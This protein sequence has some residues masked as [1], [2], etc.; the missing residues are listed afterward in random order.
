MK[1]RIEDRGLRIEGVGLFAIVILGLSLCQQSV[2]GRGA[3]LDQASQ[4]LGRDTPE[5]TDRPL[6]KVSKLSELAPT[7]VDELG[8][9]HYFRLT[10]TPLEALIGTDLAIVSILEGPGRM[11]SGTGTTAADYRAARDERVFCNADVLFLGSV[12]DFRTLLNEGATWLITEYTVAR[13]AAIA[14]TDL[15][16]RVRLGQRGGKVDVAGQT[17]STMESP[18]LRFG[19]Y[20]L[21]TANRI[22]NSR[23]LA[24]TTREEIGGLGDKRTVERLAMVR[25]VRAA[26][27]KG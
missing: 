12:S 2:L 21:F 22:P 27:Q 14:P 26:C 18:L 15:P 5:K 23:S 17:I 3:R 8:L 24:L 16:A 4:P 7:T 19:H 9:A 10:G 1:L 13:E 11:S 6:Q 20:Y 25:K